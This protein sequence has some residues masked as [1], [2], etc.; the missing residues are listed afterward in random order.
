MNGSTGVERFRTIVLMVAGLDVDERGILHELLRMLPESSEGQILNV[1]VEDALQKFRGLPAPERQGPRASFTD[2]ELDAVRAT[3]AARAMR[4][5]GFMP[6]SMPDGP[7]MLVGYGTDDLVHVFDYK[8]PSR[9]RLGMQI[10]PGMPFFA[11]CDESVRPVRP[12][13]VKDKLCPL[14]SDRVNRLELEAHVQEIG[15]K[16]GPSN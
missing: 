12:R 6:M 2:A 1:L 8:E 3:V 7:K 16:G 4:A 5:T 13:M 10:P 14:C 11:S 15:S 9:E